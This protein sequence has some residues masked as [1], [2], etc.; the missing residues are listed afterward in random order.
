ADVIG[1]AGL[2]GRDEVRE[3]A[4]R[5]AGL[6][7]LLAQEMKP[8]HPFDAGAALAIEIDIVAGGVRAE[9][10]VDTARPDQLVAHHEIQQRVPFREDLPRPLAVLL[11]LEDAREDTLQ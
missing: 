8:R 10:S 3:A 11:V 6:H 1:K 7:G 9:E 5:I 4:C 2:A